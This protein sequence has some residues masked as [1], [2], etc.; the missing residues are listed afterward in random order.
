MP[1]PIVQR[2]DAE[3]QR[4]ANLIWDKLFA[5]PSNVD[6]EIVLD[7]IVPMDL[8]YKGV[9][10]FWFRSEKKIASGFVVMS[11]HFVR[12]RPEDDHLNVDLLDEDRLL[13]RRL[14]YTGTEV[15]MAL[16]IVASDFSYLV[17][18]PNTK[19]SEPTAAQERFEVEAERRKKRLKKFFEPL[20]KELG[21]VNW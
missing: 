5:D 18:S 13:V 1:E 15:R 6:R 7:A 12:E 10:H 14:T 3:K 16:A 17:Q 4:A 8:H 9:D 19:P 2:L 20:K 21:D 11:S